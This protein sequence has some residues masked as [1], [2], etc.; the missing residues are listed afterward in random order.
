MQ[1]NRKHGSRSSAVAEPPNAHS[2]TLPNKHII[3][4]SGWTNK[5]CAHTVR[6]MRARAHIHLFC[7]NCKIPQRTR[8]RHGD[9][10]GQT[11]KCSQE[12]VLGYNLENRTLQITCIEVRTIWFMCLCMFVGLSLKSWMCY[13]AKAMKCRNVLANPHPPERDSGA[14]IQVSS[15]ESS[16][17][18]ECWASEPNRANPPCDAICIYSDS[19]KW[20]VTP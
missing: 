13:T 9:P 15:S 18:T 3:G 12:V 19:R 16:M 14:P 1:S 8:N 20:W 2:H 10:G 6:A 11:Q 4:G 7:I 5:L 17:Q